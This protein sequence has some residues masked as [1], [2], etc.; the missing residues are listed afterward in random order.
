MG[1]PECAE[2]RDEE[3]K[4]TDRERERGQFEFAFVQ[5]TSGITFSLREERRGQ[6]LVGSKG[7][8]ALTDVDIGPDHVNA[9]LSKTL[10][11]LKSTYQE[12][13]IMSSSSVLQVVN[14]GH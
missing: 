6:S 9:I 5:L 8:I 1:W 4:Q 12:L 14:E 11:I 2:R 3:A 13:C 7:K 10:K